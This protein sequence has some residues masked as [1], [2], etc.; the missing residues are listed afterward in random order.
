VYD[1]VNPILTSK[2]NGWF[3]IKTASSR[4]A[5]LTAYKNSST[6]LPPIKVDGTPPAAVGLQAA[7]VGPNFQALS[8]H[9][10]FGP[11]IVG[12]RA[13]GTQRAGPYHDT[14]AVY[15]MI[16][17]DNYYYFV[18]NGQVSV[19]NSATP[20]DRTLAERN[21][22]DLQPRPVGAWNHPPPTGFSLV[23]GTGHTETFKIVIIRKNIIRLADGMPKL[24]TNLGTSETAVRVVGAKNLL[25]YENISD[26]PLPDIPPIRAGV[27][28]TQSY[29]NNRMMD[30]TLVPGFDMVAADMFLDANAH[31]VDEPAMQ[32]NRPLL[33][34]WG[35][36]FGF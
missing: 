15:D 13:V 24:V 4:S 7:A 31:Y 18:E 3:G 6:L 8:A 30:G 23:D 28:T 17:W 20:E 25:V 33:T 5:I 1:Q 10:G 29:F 11:I 2:W 12:N 9:G 32:V 34:G 14:S 27:T 19:A 26:L 21:I 35:G 36:G 22:I 16:V